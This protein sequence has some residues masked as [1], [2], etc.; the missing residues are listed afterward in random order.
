MYQRKPQPLPELIQMTLPNCEAPV[1]IW[2]FDPLQ[3]THPD[4]ISKCQIHKLMMPLGEVPNGITTRSPYLLLFWTQITQSDFPFPMS[5]LKQM[6]VVNPT[7]PFRGGFLDNSSN[8]S[9]AFV[10]SFKIRQSKQKRQDL[11]FESRIKAE[12]NATKGG[13]S[14]NFKRS[15][16]SPFIGGLL[17][18]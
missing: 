12:R 4:D 17:N 10:L 9:C 11:R 5:D 18:F 6:C 1:G 3:K 16:I 13:C 15:Q 8:C 14:L 2:K 7:T